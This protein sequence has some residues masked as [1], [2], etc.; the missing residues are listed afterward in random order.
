MQAV[1]ETSQQLHDNNSL[2]AFEVDQLVRQSN[3]TFN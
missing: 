1:S 3:F 2:V